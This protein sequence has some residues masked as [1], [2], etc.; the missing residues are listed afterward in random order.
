MNPVQRMGLTVAMERS[1]FGKSGGRQLVFQAPGEKELCGNLNG[2]IYL[3]APDSLTH[4][5][6]I[7]PV[8]IGKALV[9][10]KPLRDI[11]EKREQEG[12]TAGPSA[13]CRRRSSPR[14]PG[15]RRKSTPSRSSGPVTWTGETRSANGR[16]SADMRPP[17]RNG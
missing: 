14:R 9:A 17:S 5:K 11:L 7:D 16:T 4:L 1:F 13:R 3:H 8:R 10:R 2:R 6:E 15:Q 12:L